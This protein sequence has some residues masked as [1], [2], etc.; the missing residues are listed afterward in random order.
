MLRSFYLNTDYTDF[1]DFTD[2]LLES[3]LPY[4]RVI[5]AIRVP[6]KVIPWLFCG[7][8]EHGLHGFHG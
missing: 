1:T 3:P 4:I 7:F 5:R 6:Q 2:K 8:V